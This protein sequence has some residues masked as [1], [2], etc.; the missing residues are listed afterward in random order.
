MK[1]YVALLLALLMMPLSCALGTTESPVIIVPESVKEL[2]EEIIEKGLYIFAISEWGFGESWRY[3]DKVGGSRK[4]F[5]SQEE[6]QLF[7]VYCYMFNL[8]TIP[9][10]F[11]RYLT[12]ARLVYNNKYEYEPLGIH[13]WLPTHEKDYATH[14]EKEP[15]LYA[16]P[17]IVF[18][19]PNMIE[20][21]K[22]PLTLYITLNGVEYMYKVR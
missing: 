2:K 8:S 11:D 19:V 14:Y 18:K 9:Y 22:D 16:Y 20:T 10:M 7:Y 4:E 17:N 15:L 21:S 13:Q 1:R 3:Y 12:G 5:Y 6:H